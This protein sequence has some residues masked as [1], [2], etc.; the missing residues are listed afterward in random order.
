MP[1][2]TTSKARVRTVH[3]RLRR[4]LK[5]WASC[6]MTLRPPEHLVGTPGIK[7]LCPK[8]VP[9]QVVELPMDHP[10]LKEGNRDRIEIVVGPARDEVVRPWVYTTVEAAVAG[11]PSKAR[12]GDAAVLESATLTE[13]AIENAPKRRKKAQAKA[14]KAAEELTEDDFADDDEDAL[15]PEDDED[16]AVDAFDDDYEPDVANKHVR[17]EDEDEEE[18][19]A[20]PKRRRA[21][22]TRATK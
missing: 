22:R 1:R 6:G 3:V 4:M 17:D 11:N 16:D 5:Q 15:P 19:P 8:L 21:T 14:A 7:A 9:G 20:P 18:V 12:H 10:I 2:K 13:A